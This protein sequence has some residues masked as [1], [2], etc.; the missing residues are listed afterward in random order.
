MTLPTVQDVLRW[1]QSS[2]AMGSKGMREL[3]QMRQRA[4]EAWSTLK[5]P[6]EIFAYPKPLQ[7]LV[8]A[9]I[10]LSLDRFIVHGKFEERS[11]RRIA[12][13]MD[14]PVDTH[15]LLDRLGE[16]HVAWENDASKLCVHFIDKLYLR[17]LAE[18]E[19]EQGEPLREAMTSDP[20]IAALKVLNAYLKKDTGKTRALMQW[21]TNLGARW[22]DG[23]NDKLVERHAAQDKKFNR[24]SYDAFVRDLYANRLDCQATPAQASLQRPRL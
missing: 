5:L 1:C 4:G 14:A 23:Q 9:G 22:E 2:K 16:P 24:P 21:A 11:V 15:L 12:L 7:A 17:A 18:V 20:S 8:D 3:D 19:R 13:F 6:Q 10:D